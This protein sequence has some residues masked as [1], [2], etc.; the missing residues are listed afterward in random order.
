M[1]LAT[2]YLQLGKAGDALDV[3]TRYHKIDPSDATVEY[4]LSALSLERLDYLK[5]WAYLK[6]AESL[7]QKRDHSPKALKALKAELRKTC[8]DPNPST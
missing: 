7:T 2:T 1:Q 5:A 3:L 6:K 8:P 4:Y